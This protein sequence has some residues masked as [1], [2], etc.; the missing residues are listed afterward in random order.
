MFCNFR[1]FPKCYRPAYH[2]DVPQNLALSP[3]EIASLTER[4]FASSAGNLGMSF[5]VGSPN[6]VLDPANVRGAD[7][8]DLWQ[9][10]C[11]SAD[12]LVSAHK[13]D[14]QYYN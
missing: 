14:K 12:K 3:S 5:D 8:A 11:A 10:S 4:G 6:P 2:K 7:P 9:S 1:R 13:K